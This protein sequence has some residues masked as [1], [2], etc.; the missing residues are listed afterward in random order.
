MADG[1]AHSLPLEIPDVPA[2]TDVVTRVYKYGARPPEVG[3]ELVRA[4]LSAAHRYRNTLIE[5]E[6]GRRAALREAIGMVPA[7]AVADAAAHA[8]YAAM[9]AAWQLLADARAASR[10]RDPQPLLRDG[11]AAAKKAYYAALRPLSAARTAAQKDPAVLVVGDRIHELGGDLVR[12]ARSQ[13]GAFWGTYLLIEAAIDAAKKTPLWDELEPNDPGF[14][15]WTGTGQVGVQLQKGLAAED[16]WGGDTRVRIV[17][18]DPRCWTKDGR[19]ERRLEGATTRP[20]RTTLALRVG[21]NGRAP[22][23]AEFPIVM[24]RPLPEGAVVKRVNVSLRKVGPHEKWSV[25]ITLTMPR[26][27]AEPIIG[28]PRVVGVDLGWRLIEGDLRVGTWQSSAGDAGEIRA[29][30]E[31]VGRFRKVDDLRSIRDKNFNVAQATLGAW[32]DGRAGLPPWLLE[33]TATLPRW[34]SSDR[35]ARLAIAWRDRR[36]AGDLT[37]F[38]PLEAWRKQDKHLWT[39]EAHQ[40]DSSLRR[41]REGFRVAAAHLAQIYDV[42]VLEHLDLRTFARHAPPEQVEGENA[43]ARGQRQAVAPSELRLALEQAFGGRGKAVRYVPA[44]W[45][46]RTCHGCGSIESWDAAAHLRHTCGVCGTDWDQDD[47]AAKNLIARYVADPEGASTT[48]ATRKKKLAPGAVEGESKWVR[49]K[50][51][52]AQKKVRQEQ[53]AALTLAVGAAPARGRRTRDMG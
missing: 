10:T 28:A 18:V 30:A 3:A 24:H 51:A 11:Y 38:E 17:P 14:E 37:A 13:C 9:M 2:T 33:A 6:R 48:R 15:R 41:R 7:V 43:A 22:V 12:S 27:V 23:W 44:A 4:Q 34:Q 50:R 20:G 45:T 49:A 39:W 8:A 52:V 31:L 26:P 35:L 5:I 16:I 47:N 46:T 19:I 32:L 21:S 42:L 1:S 25:E 29:D 40:R 36:F 53:A